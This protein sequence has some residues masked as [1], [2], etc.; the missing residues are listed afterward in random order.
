MPEHFWNWFW[1]IALAVWL[2]SMFA[3]DI[4]REAFYAV[5][6]MKGKGAPRKEVKRL[7]RELD[8]AKA[9]IGYATHIFRDIQAADKAFPQLPQDTRD[10]VDHFLDLNLKMP[11]LPA[12][13]TKGRKS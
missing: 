11:Q 6:G 9:T 7:Q 10:S 8:E 3:G 1:T 2:T 4:I 5:I 12:P 13:N